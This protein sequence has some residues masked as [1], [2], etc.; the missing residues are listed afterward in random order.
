M[1]PRTER[2]LLGPGPSPVSARV[3]AALSAPQRSHLD[4]DVLALLDDIRARLERVFRVGPGGST[5][6]VSGTGTSGMEAAVANVTD[7]SRR[8]LVVVSGYFGDRL[9][10]ILA[11]YGA[12]VERLDVEWGRAVDPDDVRA[13]L[14][15]RRADIVAVV[16]AE[17]STGVLNPVAEVARAAREVDALVLVDAV[18]SLGAMPLD[19]AGWDLDV[20]Y[21]CSQK[22]LGAPS[23]LSPI[24]F[25][26]RA[27]SRRVPSRS[28]YLD[29]GLIEDYWIRRRYHHTIPAPLVYALAAALAEV[30]EEGLEARWERHDATHQAFA[31]ALGRLGLVLFPPPGERLWSLNAVRVPDGVD[32]AAVR[33][34]LLDRHDIEIGAG[35][36]PLAG[37]I[38]R[39]GLM[40]SGSTVANVARVARALQQV[41]D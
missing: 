34:A 13:A 33:R 6:A 41:L 36:G 29:L 25:S 18:T 21:A 3:Q 16:H 2:L 8:A 20:C 40:G 35:L 31:A 10:Q 1:L 22:G 14:R 7:Q 5:L 38:W 24:T 23:G 12:D 30:D 32:E 28:F 9:A 39:V 4:P 27:L 19:V 26:A 11:R 17:T 37:R 15:S